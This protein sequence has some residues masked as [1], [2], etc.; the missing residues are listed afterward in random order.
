MSKFGGKPGGLGGGISAGPGIG[1]GKS[2][3]PG[4][5]EEDRSEDWY[6]PK[7]RERN[8]VK[9]NACYKCQ[10]LKPD[11]E[12]LTRPKHPTPP[13]GSTVNGMVKS[14]N[15]RGF[16]F[17]MCF[18]LDEGQDIYY[19]RENVSPRLLHPDMPGEQVTFELGREGGRLVAKNIRPFGEDRNSCYAMAGKGGKVAGHVFGPKGGAKMGVGMDDEDRSRDWVCQSCQERNFLKRFECFR[20]KM[21]RTVGFTEAPENF[22]QPSAPPPMQRKTFSPHAGSRSIKEALRAEML[23]KQKTKE[24]NDD[25]SSS[26]PSEKKPKKKKKKRKRSSSSDSD[27]S[28]GKKKKRKKGS[29]SSVASSSSDCCAVE[30][31]ASSGAAAAAAAAQDPEVEKAKAEALEKLI[32]L[33]TVEPRDARMTE[34]RALLRQWHPDKNPDR[35]EVATAVFQFLQKGKAI[36]LDE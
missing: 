12:K 19:T 31:P 9:R 35:Q 16:G 5:V 17:I 24:E 23:G 29:S 26:S 1:K 32:K 3:P 33:K 22:Q 27:S 21:P 36:L 15:K 20:C 13:M 6:C 14:Y 25:G 8:F 4:F 28:K 34:W 10:E 2:Q 11:D 30:E 18:N 7:C